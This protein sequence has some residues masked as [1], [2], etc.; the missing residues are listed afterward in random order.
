MKLHP[1]VK[2]V[3]AA[4]TEFVTAC[5]AIAVKYDLTLGEA[6]GLLATRL[7]SLSKYQIRSERHPNDPDM[8]G[9]EA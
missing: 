8:G 1:R 2:I 7:A 9:D 6:I 5:H 3:A 4:E